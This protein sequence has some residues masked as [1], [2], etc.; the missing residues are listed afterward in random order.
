MKYIT[1]AATSPFE[2]GD[3]VRQDGHVFTITDICLINYCKSGQTEF[4]YELD[5]RRIYSRIEIRGE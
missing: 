4:A 5:N 2:I 1:F 3:K